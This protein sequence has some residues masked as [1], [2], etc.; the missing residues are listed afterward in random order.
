VRLGRAL[1]STRATGR[2]LWAAA[3]PA[4]RDESA[5][6]HAGQQE[7]HVGREATGSMPTMA[8]V[9]QLVSVWA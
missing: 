3:L 9:K 7:L 8:A 5:N 1:V 2:K 6:D 4:W